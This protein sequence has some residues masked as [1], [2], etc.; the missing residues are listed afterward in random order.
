VRRIQVRDGQAMGVELESGELV[1]ADAVVSDYNAVGTYLELVP[2]APPPMRRTLHALPL[3]SP[4][5]SAYLAVRASPRSPYLRFRL[6]GD[7]E[8]C[9]LLVIPGVMDP[10]STRDG[11]WPARLLSPMDHTQAERAGPAGQRAYLERVLAEPWW[12]EHVAEF[13]ILAR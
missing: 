13:R 1:G 5:V 12:R 6:P 8:P 9:R 4:G 7:G 10:T 11:W 3:Q 2:G